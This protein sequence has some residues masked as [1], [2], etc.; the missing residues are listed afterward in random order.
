MEWWSVG[1]LTDLLLHRFNTPAR[2]RDLNGA[3]RLNVLNG[4]SS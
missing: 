2:T 1:I 4:L 3:E